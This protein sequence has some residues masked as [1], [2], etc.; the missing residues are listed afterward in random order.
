MTEI[1]IIADIAENVDGATLEDLA[2]YRELAHT[3]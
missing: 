1:E 3:P 2:L